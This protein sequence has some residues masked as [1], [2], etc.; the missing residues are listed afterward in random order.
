M[1]DPSTHDHPARDHRQGPVAEAGGGTN[2]E[3]GP[4]RSSASILGL[5]RHNATGVLA[6][7]PSM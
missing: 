2:R 6:D 5:T 1:T 7:H 4:R 3:R